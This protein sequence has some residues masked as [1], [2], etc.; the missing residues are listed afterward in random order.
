M[1][2][3]QP[4]SPDALA[5]TIGE[6]IHGRD[7]EEVAEIFQMAF[8]KLPGVEL[9]RPGDADYPGEMAPQPSEY[10]GEEFDIRDRQGRR[11]GIKELVQIIQEA[12]DEQEI[13]EGVLKRVAT[14]MAGKA[15]GGDAGEVAAGYKNFYDAYVEKHCPNGPKG[16][17]A[18]LAA[19][20][21]I[22][23][24]MAKKGGGGIMNKLK[25]LF[26]EDANVMEIIQ[27]IIDEGHY[28]DMGDEDEMYNVI[29]S[30]PFAVA[31]FMDLDHEK[32]EQAWADDPSRLSDIALV[33][34]AKKFDLDKIIVYD[35]E[36][37]L[38]N[39]EELEDELAIEIPKLQAL[40]E[41]IAMHFEGRQ[42]HLGETCEEAHPDEE[43]DQWEQSLSEVSSEKQRRW[44]CAQKDKPAS[45]RADSLSAAEAEE[46]CK[47]KIEE[48]T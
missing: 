47:S 25:G 12:I 13:E 22:A 19:K 26:K 30:H 46:M 38:A 20:T 23:K 15:A 5:A 10:G 36:G 41:E 1:R 44:A 40:E 48:E 32:F 27:E 34:Y 8:E 18:A 14:S 24:D 39:R 3:R 16:C 4:I 35:G 37:D 2:P 43:H 29:G 33:N 28:H 21:M 6:L 11:V 7:P 9:S 42:K 17:P 31:D 45:E